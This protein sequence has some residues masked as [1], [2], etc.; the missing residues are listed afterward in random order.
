MVFDPTDLDKQKNI[1][2]LLALFY[3]PL[4][5][6]SFFEKET[7]SLPRLAYTEYDFYVLVT[8]RTRKYECICSYNTGIETLAKE[9][10]MLC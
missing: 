8:R 4:H 3:P 1:I 6:A 2:P 5:K 10:C 7:R 9:Y